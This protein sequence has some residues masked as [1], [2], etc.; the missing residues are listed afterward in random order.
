MWISHIGKI[1]RCVA[2]VKEYTFIKTRCLLHVLNSKRCACVCL[3]A[4]WV[5]GLAVGVGVGVGWGMSRT[6][7]L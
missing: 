2:S 3:C 7:R 1:S 4:R 5:G 6:Y